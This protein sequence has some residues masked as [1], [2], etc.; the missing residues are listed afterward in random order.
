[1]SNAKTQP[2]EPGHHRFRAGHN[3]A[4][5]TSDVLR[6]TPMI[7]RMRGLAESSFIALGLSVTADAVVTRVVRCRLDIRHARAERPDDTR[8]VNRCAT[9]MMSTG[10]SDVAQAQIPQRSRMSVTA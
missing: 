8:R 9:V 4:S 2:I 1:M 7:D 6:I 3:D 5:T 10:S